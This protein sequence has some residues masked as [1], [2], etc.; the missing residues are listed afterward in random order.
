MKRRPPP[1]PSAPPPPL[2]KFEY[3]TKAPGTAN[4]IG[5]IISLD[6]WKSKGSKQDRVSDIRAHLLKKKK[7]IPSEPVRKKAKRSTLSFDFEDEVD[8][9]RNDAPAISKCPDEDIRTE[10][11][12]DAE[13]EKKAAAREAEKNRQKLEEEKRVKNELLEITYSYWDGSGHRKKIQVKKKSTI[14][15][16]LDA[17]CD[18]LRKE[19]RVLRVSMGSHL[20]YIKEDC[21]VPHHLTF[22]ELIVSKARGLTGPLFHFDVH[23]DVRLVGDLRIDRDDSHPGKII[24]S[25]WYSRNKHIFPAS[26]W[27]YY[28]ADADVSK[29]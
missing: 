6:E 25:T 27:K 5:G 29:M 14:L 20:M 10:F 16:F 11:L 9:C 23:D 19:F 2:S 21:I 17:V 13:R 4:D 12:P 28:Q 3:K 26:R 1:P 7:K 15:E 22:Y 18:S 24:T 8:V